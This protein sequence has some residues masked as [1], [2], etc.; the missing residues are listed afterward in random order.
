MA[1]KAPLRSRSRPSSSR[2]LVATSVLPLASREVS[3][4]LG[5]ARRIVYGQYYPSGHCSLC[6]EESWEG[7]I[8]S[9][10]KAMMVSFK[11]FGNAEG[12]GTDRGARK[13]TSS[14]LFLYMLLHPFP[15]TRIQ[16][17]MGFLRPPGINV[18]VLENYL[19]VCLD[20]MKREEGRG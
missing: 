16:V 3:S 11:L 8:A 1:L 13:A 12:D 7:E 14:Q 20:S 10:I 19:K 2:P 5:M 15:P 17:V 6:C 9:V 18:P 4:S